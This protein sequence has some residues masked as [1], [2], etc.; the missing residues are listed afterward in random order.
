MESVDLFRENAKKRTFQDGRGLKRR[1][2]GMKEEEGKGEEGDNK[3][4][5]EKK[6]MKK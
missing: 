6:K 1:R 2:R 3:K 4:K 5:I